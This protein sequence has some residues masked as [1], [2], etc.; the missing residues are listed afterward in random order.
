MAQKIALDTT[1][2]VSKDQVSADLG[3]E[4]IILNL[5]TGVYYE[6]DAVGA[7]IWEFIQEPR[8]VREVRDALLEEYDVDA[9]RCEERLIRV[10]TELARSGLLTIADTA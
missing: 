8:T 7:R 2:V 3:G 9:E 1:I 4:A 5:K 6:L 10:L